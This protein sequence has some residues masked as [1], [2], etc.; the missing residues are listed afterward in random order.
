VVNRVLSKTDKAKKRKIAANLKRLREL[1]KLMS[2][3]AVHY[4][5]DGSTLTA[6]GRSGRI[7]LVWATEVSFLIELLLKDESHLS[8]H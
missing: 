5:E 6:H 7:M 2:E 8:K 1:R 3:L 4:G